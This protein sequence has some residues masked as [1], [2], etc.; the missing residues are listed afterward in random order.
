M[1]FH[2]AR[3]LARGLYLEMMRPEIR[4]PKAEKTK[5]TVPVKRLRNMKL[6]LFVQ[7]LK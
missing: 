1:T 5:P 4:I 6:Y 3:Y 2:A 7:I